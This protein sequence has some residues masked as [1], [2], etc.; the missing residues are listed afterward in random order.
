MNKYSSYH[1]AIVVQL[2]HVCTYLAT[3]GNR[4]YSANA[5]ADTGGKFQLLA[6]AFRR[7]ATV[8]N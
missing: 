7:A 4:S 2:L 3:V 8:I 1:T 5:R 6:W